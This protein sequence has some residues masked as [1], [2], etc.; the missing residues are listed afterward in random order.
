MSASLS[1]ENFFEVDQWRRSC[2]EL[3]TVHPSFNL[4]TPDSLQVAPQDSNT[5]NTQVADLILNMLLNIDYDC[6]KV[7]IIKLVS[8]SD[9][10]MLIEEV[11]FSVP[12]VSQ[13]TFNKKPIN[14]EDSTPPYA[15]DEHS[16][17]NH[18][19]GRNKGL[20]RDPDPNVRTVGERMATSRA[21][22]KVVKSLKSVGTLE[23]Q[24]LILLRVLSNPSIRNLSS[25]I[26]INMKEIKLGQQL[27][28][29]ARKLIWHSKNSPGNNGGRYRT[30]VAKR[31]VVKALC[32]G[33]LPTPT[34]ETGNDGTSI[35]SRRAIS[36]RQISKQLG[37]SYGTGHRTLSSVKKKRAD[38]AEGTKE[39]WIMVT[40]EEQRT[41][42]TDELLNAL[43]YWIQNND[44]VQH[45]PF[46]DNLVIKRDRTGLIVRDPATHQPLGV[47][48]MMLMCNQSTNT[49]QSHDRTFRRCNRE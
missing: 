10:R 19:R 11:L 41:K 36:M 34:K 6:R 33:L 13:A 46:K 3:L 21:K 7:I 15:V 20:P 32:L 1:S 27:L 12:I 25:S 49:A 23:Q 42:Y 30:S 43:E 47:T 48:N 26:R 44:M 16:F 4:L 45:S 39:G 29:C 40:D 9:V 8:N 17:R 35:A 28:R 24:R 22:T 38:I 2:G 5:T 37:F 14:W 31:S 18:T